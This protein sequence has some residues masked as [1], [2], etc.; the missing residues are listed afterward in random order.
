[1]TAADFNAAHPVGTPVDAYPITRDYPPLVTWTR[2]A[3]WETDGRPVV[4]VEGHA[5][6]IALTHIDTNPTAEEAS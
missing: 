1:M 2:S 6:R 4:L 3:A 5:D